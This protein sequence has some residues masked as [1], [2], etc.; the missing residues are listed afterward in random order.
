MTNGCF[1]IIHTGHVRY[2]NKAR[3]IGD[4]LLVAIND[5]D[6]VKRLKGNSRPINNLE[7]RAVVLN[8]LSSVDLVVTFNEDTPEK[9][10]E[11]LKPDTLVKGGDY[12][13]EEIIGADFVKRSGGN[14]VVLPFEKGN[15]TTNILKKINNKE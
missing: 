3:S 12:K 5:D 8:G 10:I 11:F 2:L 13:E 6:S 14:V 7:N 15:S 9:L 1:D 4:F